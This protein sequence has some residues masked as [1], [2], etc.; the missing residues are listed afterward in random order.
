MK[1]KHMKKII[2][3]TIFSLFLILPAYS[4]GINVGIS[5]TT[6][7]FHATGTETEVAEKSTDD[8]TGVVGYGSVFIEKTLG[9]R[10]AIGME[11]VPS[12]LSSDTQE[13][14]VDDQ[15]AAADGAST[16]VTN[17]FSVDFEDLNTYYLA[18]NLNENLYVKAGMV[19]VD[20]IT[21]ET[22]GTGSTYGNTDMDGEMYAIGYNKTFGETMF[23]R[24]EG[25]YMDFGSTSVTASNTD[26]KVELSK[27]EG[28][29][30]KLSIGKS[31]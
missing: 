31:F 11:H 23:L 10:F 28:L 8:A 25:S 27:L 24:V 3:S 26:N 7:V 22:L 9:D 14:V 1:E 29:V 17:K 20:V 2:L 4:L 19:T 12:S 30:G 15:K 5:G 16:R 6:G 21:K 13:T 18:F